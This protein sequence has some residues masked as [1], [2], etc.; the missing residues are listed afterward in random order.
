MLI[1]PYYTESQGKV[2]ISRQQASDF[3]K[4]V[5][6]DFNPLHDIETK[7]FCVPGDLLFSMILSKYGVSERMAFTFSGMVSDATDLTL[8]EPAAK[9]TLNDSNG[10]EYI[11]VERA[12]KTSTEATMINNLTTS[13]V[14]FSGMTFPHLLVPLLK[15]QGVMINPGRPLVIYQSMLIDL[16]NLNFNA[17]ELQ[18]DTENTIMEVAGKRGNARLAFNL[19]SVGNIGAGKIVGRGEKHMVLSGLRDFESSAVDA[20]IDDYSQRKND[21]KSNNFKD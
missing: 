21:F 15:E 7:K 11:S 4:N 13:Y 2:V 17:V 8:P 16:L 5:A 12:G 1:A 3:A 14:S 9:L 19:V 6:D 10:K 20:L 18:L